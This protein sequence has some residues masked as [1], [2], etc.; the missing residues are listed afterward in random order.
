MSQAERIAAL[1]RFG[2][3]E[4][5]AAFLCLAA[6]HGGYFIRR[7]FGQFLG[8]QDGGSVTGLVQ[9]ALALGHAR[10]STWRQNTQLYHLGSRP[11]Y[12][13]LGQG[14]NRNRR[15]R[16]WAAVKN[17]IMGLDFVLGHRQ[18]HYLATEQEKRDYFTETLALDPSVFPGKRYHSARTDV[19]TTRYF[20]EKYPLFLAEAMPHRESGCISFCFVDEG[21]VTLS[22]FETYLDQY[23]SLFAL[24]HAFQLIYVADHERH[25]TGART[26]FAR[27]L[28]Q[29]AGAERDPQRRHVKRLL[30]YFKARHLYETQQ[31][32]SLDRSQLT[33]LRD[34]RDEFSSQET[35][36]LYACW[37]MAG[38]E[39]ICE[40]PTP[41]R[42]V[43]GSLRG[44]F[45]TCLLA[46]DYGLFGNF[47]PR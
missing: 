35:D 19:T 12:Q 44:T 7:Q 28:T 18:H 38:H 25:L 43:T 39:A 16:E 11:F 15:P 31:W 26:V 24:L 37:Q 17:K 21:L 41:K 5:E 42:A 36:A 9:K 47:P 13:A 8:R 29:A 27:F 32:A 45:S 14:E 3:S 6:L 4:A 20:V 22:R 46:H 1:Q 23:R 2:Y 10:T 34:A 30:E 33:R 40:I